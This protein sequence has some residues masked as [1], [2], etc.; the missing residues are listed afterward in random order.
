V[1]GPSDV[2]HGFVNSGT[3]ELRLLAI[4]GA[5]RF[6]TEWLGEADLDWASPPRPE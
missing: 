4:H 2:P 1:V 6:S 5:S 3:G